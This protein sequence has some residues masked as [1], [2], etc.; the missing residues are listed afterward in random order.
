VETATAPSRQTLEAM[1]DSA[2]EALLL[3]NIFNKKVK[4]KWE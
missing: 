2:V 1:R 3:R 4:L